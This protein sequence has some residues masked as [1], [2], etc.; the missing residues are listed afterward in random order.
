MNASDKKTARLIHYII[1]TA[2]LVF[3]DQ[4]TKYAAVIRLKGSEPYVLIRDVLEFRYLENQGAAFSIFQNQQIMFYILTAVFLVL[5][6]YFLCRIPK[7]ARF[8][9]LTICLLFLSA[10]AVG[11][12]IDRILHRYVVDFIYFKLIDF[13]IFN[14]A[15][16]FVSVSVSVLILLVL[17]HYRDADFSFLKRTGREK[18]E[19][20]KDTADV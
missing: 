20:G 4:I 5:A 15:D 12:L 10:G 13:P 18:A 17:F 6:V 14:V 19:E 2:V 1:L 8:R 3:F 16:I 9:P 11:N 7:T